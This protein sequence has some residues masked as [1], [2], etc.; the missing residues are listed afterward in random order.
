MDYRYTNEY[1]VHV[2]LDNLVLLC[3]PAVNATRGEELSEYLNLN[4][5]QISALETAFAKNCYI[6]KATLMQ[7]SRQTGLP[8][9]LIHHWFRDRRK[10]ITSGK[11]EQELTISKCCT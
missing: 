2:T 1:N 6:R 8:V 9:K 3:I 10:L 5:N 4:T 7:V 11:V